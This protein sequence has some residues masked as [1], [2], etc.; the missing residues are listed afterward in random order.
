MDT[1]VLVAK[2]CISR[3]RIQGILRLLLRGTLI[4]IADRHR[5]ELEV[6]AA[7]AVEVPEAGAGS[8]S[9]RF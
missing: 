4:T 2:G 9:A 7:V 3:R 6:A 1:L 8:R 5:L